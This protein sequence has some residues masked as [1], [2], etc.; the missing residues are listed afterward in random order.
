LS[1]AVV[2]EAFP[3][4]IQT[5]VDARGDGGKAENHGAQLESTVRV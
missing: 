2:V 5:I 3:F 1:L 4:A